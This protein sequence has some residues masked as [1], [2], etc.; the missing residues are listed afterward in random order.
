LPIELEDVN[1]V[2]RR[3]EPDETR[4]LR[5]VN[6]TVGD[7]EFLLICGKNGSGKSTLLSCMSGLQKPSAGTVSIDGRPAGKARDRIAL[8][9]QFPERALFERTLFDDVA[10]GLRNGGMDE[11]QVLKAVAEAVRTVGLSEELLSVQPATLSHGQKRLAALAC[12]IAAR[13]KYLFLDEPTAGLDAQGRARILGVLKRLNR[14]GV[15]VV[16]ASHDLAHMIG[17]CK[18]IVILDEG[19]ISADCKPEDLISLECLESTGLALPYELTVA[20]ALRLCGITVQGMSPVELA[21]GVGRMCGHE[22]AG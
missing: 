9:V 5:D 10:F 13:P 11:K 4:A 7:G 3:G 2:Y 21:E 8:A 12:I 22:N 15:A 1:Q 19:V 18:R 20:R 16:V 6:L 17:A 14:D